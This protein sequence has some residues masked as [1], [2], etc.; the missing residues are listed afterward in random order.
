MKKVWLSAIGVCAIMAF[1]ACESSETK[2]DTQ[3]ATEV[4][5]EK[6]DEKFDSSG[7]E[8][9]ADYVVQAAAGN[10]AEI[11]LAK[12]AQTKSADA[13]IKKM[14]GELIA[15]HTALLG[16]VK[17][18]AASK[19]ISVPAAAD[20]ECVNKVKDLNETK[21]EDFNKK[22]LDVMIDKHEK[23]IDKYESI[24]SKTDDAELKSWVTATIPKVKEHLNML[25]MK[26]DKIKS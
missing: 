13:E 26:K 9:T 5:E 10:L 14:S 2:K 3:D 8:K 15:A 20:E 22:W 1:T 11:E 6:N 12:T 16:E 25:Q 18:L 7:A 23:T 21:A 24:Q 4:A 17:A 19:N